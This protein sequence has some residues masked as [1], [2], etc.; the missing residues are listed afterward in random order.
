MTRRNFLDNGFPAVKKADHVFK[1]HASEK[2]FLTSLFKRLQ[3][4]CD[5]IRR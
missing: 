4:Q 2:V 1:I 5:K 3:F